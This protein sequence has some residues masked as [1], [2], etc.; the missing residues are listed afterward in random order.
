MIYTVG[1]SHCENAWN[2][3]PGVITKGRGPMTMYS[4]GIYRH[5]AVEDIPLDAPVVFC[6]GEID[7]RCHVH[8]HQPWKETIDKLV[9]GYLL[10][11]DENAK[12]HP[13]IWIFNVVPPPRRALANENPGFPFV[14]SDDERLSYVKYM[15]S[16]LSQSKYSFIDVYD[17]YA[18]P[19]GFLRMELSDAHV[20]IADKGPLEEWI[21]VKVREGVLV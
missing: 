11:I 8:K 15:N 14:G 5:I 17:R 18:D 4:F 1:D 7:C 20:H 3:I 12:I 9:E 13:N 19:E 10:A 21:A 2:R 6:W 16:L